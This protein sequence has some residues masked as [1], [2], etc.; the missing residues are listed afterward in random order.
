MNTENP[1]IQ[2]GNPWSR[3]VSGLGLI[4]MAAIAIWLM[5]VFEDQLRL[6]KVIGI[7]FAGGVFGIALIAWGVGEIVLDA[8]RRGDWKQIGIVASAIAIL[9][10]AIV[11]GSYAMRSAPPPPG[12]E[13]VAA[14]GRQRE[15]EQV[16]LLLSHLGSGFRSVGATLEWES[17]LVQ[18]QFDKEGKLEWA[19][20]GGDGFNDSYRGRFPYGLEKSDSPQMVLEKLGPHDQ[21]NRAGDRTFKYSKRGMEISFE[22]DKVKVVELIPPVDGEISDADPPK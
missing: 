8:R 18:L 7:V 2:Q 12:E 22:Y 17:Q 19:R 3:V 14:M 1:P 20:L 16:Q 11:G 6:G 21:G 10:V 15:D 13:F 4:L 5:R 9:I